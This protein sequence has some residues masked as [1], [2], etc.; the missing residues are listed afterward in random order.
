MGEG[1][2]NEPQ[3]TNDHNPSDITVPLVAPQTVTGDS[4]STTGE[5][6]EL[7]TI[8]T[9]ISTESNVGESGIEEYRFC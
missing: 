3:R 2:N 8:P 5:K 4:T 6:E 7:S 1:D 9:T